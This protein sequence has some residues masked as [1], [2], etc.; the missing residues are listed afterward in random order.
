[1]KK[2]CVCLMLFILISALVMSCA[3]SETQSLVR[4]GVRAFIDGDIDK[5][6]EY[7]RQAYEKSPDDPFVL[8]NMGYI[9]EMEGDKEKAFEFFK[10]AVEK[11]NNRTVDLS[12]FKD[13]EGRSINDVSKDNYQRL[14]K[15]LGK[16]I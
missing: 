16:E 2:V 12:Q 15:V 5:F 9:H 4:R 14:A 7:T 10:K 1:M 8:N 13:Q 3:M 6:K 11:S